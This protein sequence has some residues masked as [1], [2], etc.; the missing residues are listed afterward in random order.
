MESSLY[1]LLIPIYFRT[2][3]NCSRECTI[4]GITIPKDMSVTIGI[5]VLH[6]DPEVWP[7]P[8]K[9]DPER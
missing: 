1:V 9:Y 3:R 6:Y 2:D 4:N 8:H 7:E 5:D